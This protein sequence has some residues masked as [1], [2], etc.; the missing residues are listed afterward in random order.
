MYP[1]ICNLHFT[2]FP[3]RHKFSFCKV[4][5]RPSVMTT[6]SHQIKHSLQYF[7]LQQTAWLGQ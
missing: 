2:R 7:N 3:Q 5:V 1:I 4:H 6:E